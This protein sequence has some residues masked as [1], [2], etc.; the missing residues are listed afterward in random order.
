MRI[1]KYKC[2]LNVKIIKLTKESRIIN[3]KRWRTYWSRSLNIIIDKWIWY[4][5]W[6]TIVSFICYSLETEWSWITKRKIRIIFS[7]SD[8]EIELE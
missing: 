5:E 8:F 7:L 2:F 6:E 1:S 3:K 4:N